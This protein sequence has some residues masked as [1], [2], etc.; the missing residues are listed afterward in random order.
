MLVAESGAFM[1]TVGGCALLNGAIN[2][3]FANLF[4]MEESVCRPGVLQYLLDRGA[5]AFLFHCCRTRGSACLICVVFMGVGLLLLW[6]TLGDEEGTDNSSMYYGTHW[7]GVDSQR[8]RPLHVKSIIG[9]HFAL[10]LL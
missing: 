1:G 2:F 7:I 9:R 4:S 10:Q 5:S 6:R 8:E 3:I